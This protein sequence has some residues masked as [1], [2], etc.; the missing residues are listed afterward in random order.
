MM[1]LKK[2]LRVIDVPMSKANEEVGID[3][4]VFVDDDI[5]LKEDNVG[6]PAKKRKG[7]ANEEVMSKFSREKNE[8]E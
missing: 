4:N 2:A 1:Y 3:A 5:V 8:D 6:V 7:K